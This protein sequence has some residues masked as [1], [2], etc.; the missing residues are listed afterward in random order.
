[1]K[2]VTSLFFCSEEPDWKR[3][4]PPPPA[5]SKR[6]L[7]VS[8]IVLS[9]RDL[10]LALDSR[11]VRRVVCAC[12]AT[13]PLAID[14]ASNTPATCFTLNLKPNINDY[15]CTSSWVCY[16]GTRDYRCET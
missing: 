1:M 16:V 2:K 13:A 4:K 6:G 8:A 9:I 15:S 3:R 10:R 12:T 7:W 14:A 11:R 5:T